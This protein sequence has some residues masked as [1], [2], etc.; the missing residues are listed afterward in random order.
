MNRYSKCF[1]VLALVC[2][3]IIQGV[4][5][6]TVGNIAISPSSDLISGQTQVRSTFVINFPSTGGYT[7]D[8]ENTLQLFTE[9]SNPTWTYAR[10]QDGIENPTV[11]QV[12]Q[13]FNIHGFELSYKKAELSMKVTLEAVAPTVA[14][15]EEKI[16]FAVRELNAAG[17]KI[18]SSEVSRKK[19][20]VNPAQIQGSISESKN[21]LSA[22]Q[23]QIDQLA[24]SGIDV[25]ALQ[26]KYN[27]ASSAIQNAEKTL[28]SQKSRNSLPLQI[29]PYPLRK[30]LASELGNTEDHQ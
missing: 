28:I 11:T 22:L 8:D 9:M 14:N 13:N 7:F 3:F 23:G 17:A 18:A 25:S 29:P 10:V 26:Q 21:K 15:S 12:G 30:Q 2:L 6:F 1:L 27:D 20:V 19:L 4:A 24:V 16:V 5:A